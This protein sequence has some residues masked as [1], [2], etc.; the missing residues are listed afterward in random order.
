MIYFST[1][2][3]TSKYRPSCQ[4]PE[5]SVVHMAWVAPI[6]SLISQGKLEEIA[7][8]LEQTE[9]EVPTRRSPNEHGQQRCV[10]KSEDV[11]VFDGWPYALHLLGHVLNGDL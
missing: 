8:Y 10:C 9:L 11:Y 5:K 1:M 6:E 7:P 4:L 2:K 3:L